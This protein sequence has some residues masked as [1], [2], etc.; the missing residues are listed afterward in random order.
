[1][2]LNIRCLDLKTELTGRAQA[3]LKGTRK[4][5]V[6]PLSCS[7]GAASERIVASLL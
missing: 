1:M 6:T 2:T 7:C 4:D 5:G 3:L